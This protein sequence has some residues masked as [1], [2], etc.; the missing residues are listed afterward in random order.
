MSVMRSRARSDH[1]IRLLPPP[2][3]Y[4]S[5]EYLE[6]RYSRAQRAFQS[7]PR[8]AY[9]SH[10]TAGALRGL[11]APP[12]APIHV[13][14]L[15]GQRRL[16]TTG[17]LLHRGNLE[18]HRSRFGAI[19]VSDPPQILVELARSHLLFD[20][21]PLAD[22]IL[23][24]GQYSITQLR[25]YRAE[26][27]PPLH[28]LDDAIRLARAGSESPEESRC[29]L[30]LRLAGL[31]E[32][33]LQKEVTDPETG[34]TYALDMAYEDLLIA[35]EYDGEHHE[36]PNQKAYDEH[37]RKRLADIGWHFH[38]ATKR[39]IR[40][41]PAPLLQSIAADY[42]DRASRPVNLSAAWQAEFIQRLQ[43]A[44]GTGPLPGSASPES[45]SA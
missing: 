42:N 1:P 43:A 25:S 15:P 22:S 8:G 29:R 18:A 44:P 41:D 17:V 40:H 30:L 20:L 34:I 32:P 38:I 5:R 11:W 36:D 27:A 21:L 24:K 31:P 26:H 4:V 35:M 3:P 16:N 33:Q 39:D 12:S 7:A 23:A 13:S 28:R 19:T 14:V 2:D 9:I 45:R 37:R 6:D 10:H